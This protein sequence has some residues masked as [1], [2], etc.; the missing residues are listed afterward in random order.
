MREII[1]TLLDLEKEARN[2]S[3]VV[4]DDEYATQVEI[5]RRITQIEREA[6]TR[7]ATLKREA[8]N[9][10]NERIKEIESDYQHKTTAME[11]FFIRAHDNLV[12]KIVQEVLHGR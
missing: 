7:I 11:S 4:E 2:A 8:T 9:E 6:K 3:F 12:D 10:T 5:E 1:N